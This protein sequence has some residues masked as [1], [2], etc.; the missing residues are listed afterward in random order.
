MIA[1]ELIVELRFMYRPV[2]AAGRPIKDVKEPLKCDDP[3][4]TGISQN[5]TMNTGESI[6]LDCVVNNDSKL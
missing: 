2:G 6:Q 3:D 1:L 4:I 5:T